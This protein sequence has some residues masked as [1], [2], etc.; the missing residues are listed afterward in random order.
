MKT[1]N[2]GSFGLGLAGRW[3]ASM[4]PGHEDREYSASAMRRAR[5][6]RPQWSPV[7]K[8]GNTRQA[9]TE[10]TASI[11]PQW[12]PVMKTGN[13]WSKIPVAAFGDWPQWS[14]VMKTGNTTPATTSPNGDETPQWSPVM[15]TGNTRWC[16]CPAA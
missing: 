8:T 13:T 15:K 3:G 14:P 2:T 11:A 1:G 5:M 10:L 6:R 9:I 7:M 4:E 16:P 12:S